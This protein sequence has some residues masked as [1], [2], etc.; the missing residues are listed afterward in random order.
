[1]TNKRTNW[2]YLWRKELWSVSLMSG[3]QALI[4]RREQED[5]I[6]LGAVF[7]DQE[8]SPQA[9]R[10]LGEYLGDGEIEKHPQAAQ[11][12]GVGGGITLIWEAGRQRLKT[13]G[14]GQNFRHP[15]PNGGY[16]WH[17]DLVHEGET[18][19]LKQC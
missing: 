2:L 16:G 6:D 18:G 12:P 5:S 14:Q 19:G 9:Q 17:T 15:Y 7:R 13:G 4:V 10:S 8:L 11:V 1:M 3:C